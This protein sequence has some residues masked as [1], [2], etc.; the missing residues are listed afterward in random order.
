MSDAGQLGTLEADVMLELR[1]QGEA[2][3]QSVLEALNASAADRKRAYTTVLTV[4][5]RLIAGSGRTDSTP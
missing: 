3:V 1:T 4:M 5:Q 2:T